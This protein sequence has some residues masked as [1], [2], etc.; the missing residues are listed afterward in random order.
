MASRPTLLRWPEL[1][2]IGR[3]GH[4]VE[5]I[6]PKPPEAYQV[7]SDGAWWTV[8]EV[9]TAATRRQT[10]MEIGGSSCSPRENMNQAE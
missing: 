7:A 9:A 6:L 1:D 4:I 3:S 8:R 10:S 5:D 2:L